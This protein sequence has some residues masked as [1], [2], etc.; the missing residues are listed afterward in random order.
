MI[1]HLLA[2]R[3]DVYRTESTADGMGGMRT[4]RVRVAE[5][6]PARVAQPSASERVAADMARARLTHRG[7]LAPGTD[8]RRGDELRGALGER[9]RVNA[10]VSP[11]VPG[12]YVRVDLEQLQ[13]GERYV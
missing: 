6:V 8:V 12:V 10:V 7:Y 11:S 9:Y 4:D 13:H 1:A 2:E 5:Q 3:V